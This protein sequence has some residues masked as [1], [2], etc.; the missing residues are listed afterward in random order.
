M[1]TLVLKCPPLLYDIVGLRI[2]AWYIRGFPLGNVYFRSKHGA[3]ARCASA[4]K[5]VCK[6]IDVLETKTVSLNHIL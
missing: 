5:V 1:F 2:R 3:S 6:D 4:V